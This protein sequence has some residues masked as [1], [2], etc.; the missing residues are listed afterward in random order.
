MRASTFRRFFRPI[1]LV[2]PG[3]LFLEATPPART[4]AKPASLTALEIQLD[5]HPCAQFAGILVAVQNGYYRQQGLEVSVTAADAAMEPFARISQS[6]DTIGISEA[7]S[8]LVEAAKGTPIQAFATMM[9]TTPFSLL[10]LRTS[11][12]TT[13]QSLK[14]KR[15]GLYGDGRRAINELL[16]YNGM[17]LADVTLVDIP[18]SLDPLIQG[19]V[20]AMQGYSIDEAVRLNLSHHPVNV[21]PMSASGYISYAEVLFAGKAMIQQHPDT[22]VR[23][24]RA[25][26][27]GWLWAKAHPRKTAQMIV[28]KYLPES[29]VEEQSESLA[30]AIPLLDAETHDSRIGAMQPE[31]WRQSIAMF[32]RFQGGGKNVTADDLVTYS[33]L[34]RLDGR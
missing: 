8:L 9:Q 17:T 4:W 12:L 6:T 33:I 31:T 24:V 32:E 28:E 13:F 15:I 21:I 30:Q 3:L 19:Q 34:R 18:F 10:T 22:L 1:A 14:G 11:G 23:F 26:R 20:D 25:T 7:D 5:W 29:S 16:H 27:Q 2:L